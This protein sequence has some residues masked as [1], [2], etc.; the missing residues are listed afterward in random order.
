MSRYYQRTFL[1]LGRLDDLFTY[2]VMPLWNCHFGTKIAI[3]NL[4]A[5]I[6]L[7]LSRLVE[8]DAH[9]HS[10]VERWTLSH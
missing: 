3:G 6:Q 10:L 1:S 4:Q 9:G 2:D 8:I 7:H 5:P